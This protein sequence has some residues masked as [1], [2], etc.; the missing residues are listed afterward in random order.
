MRYLAVICMLLASSLAIAADFSHEE[1]VVRA[2]YARLSY[3]AR[4]GVLL[5][6]AQDARVGHD[7]TAADLVNGTAGQSAGWKTDDRVVSF[8]GLSPGRPWLLRVDYSDRRNS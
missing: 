2:A 5:R 4:T 7:E 8:K 1:T 6:Y 3:A